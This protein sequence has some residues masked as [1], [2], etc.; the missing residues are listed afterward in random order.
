[1]FPMICHFQAQVL[2]NQGGTVLRLKI[3]NLRGPYF[4]NIFKACH[5]GYLLAPSIKSFRQ[6]NFH[7]QEEFMRIVLPSTVFLFLVHNV[8]HV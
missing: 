3:G 6:N 1:M 8:D 7:R 4:L 5:S 2:G